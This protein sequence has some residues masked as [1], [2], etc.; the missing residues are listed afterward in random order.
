MFFKRLFSN[1]KEPLFITGSNFSA[2]IE[3]LFQ[4]ANKFITIVSP[5]IKFSSRIIDILSLKRDEGIQITI[6]YR[7]D[8]QY[9]NIANHLYKRSNLHAKCYLTENAF[10]I[11]SMN[12]YDYS[13]TNNDEFGVLIKKDD[14]PC[15]YAECRSEINR[16]TRAFNGQQADS[17]LNVGESKEESDEINSAKKYVKFDINQKYD[18]QKIQQI[19]QTDVVL[20]GGIN[21][22][23]HNEIVL[24]W[25]SLSKYANYQLDDVIYFIGQNTGTVQQKLIYGNKDLY[26]SYQDDNIMIY[27]FKDNIYLGRVKLKDKPFYKYN[28][29]CFPLIFIKEQ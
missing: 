24:M 18:S 26:D 11:G 12:M 16:I 6:F 13:Q 3:K 8:F 4:Q 22:I 21:K 29:L 10:I 2:N 15:A 25:N 7:K 19:L 27:L 17:D 14:F 20:R 9:K 1:N 5:Y 23:N 28:Q